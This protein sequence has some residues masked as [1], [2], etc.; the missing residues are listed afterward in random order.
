VGEQDT[1]TVVD[2]S[3]G[4]TNQVVIEQRVESL[5]FDDSSSSQSVDGAVQ[6]S[7]TIVDNRK[8]NHHRVLIMLL[9][10][11]AIFF[12]AGYYYV[13][14]L[15]TPPLPVAQMGP[16]V[17]PMI[18]VPVRPQM[19]LPVAIADHGDETPVAETETDSSVSALFVDSA[20]PLFTVAVGPFISDGDLQQ[21]TRRLEELGLQP[22]KVPGRGQVTMIRLL[23][24]V[25]PEAEARNRLKE[26][27][28]TVK[29]IFLLPLGDKLA[30]YAG[31][32]HQESRALKMQNELALQ[33]VKVSLVDSEVT[34]NGTL[35][36]AL[37][38]DQQT[39][40]EVAAHIS[41]LGLHTQLLEKK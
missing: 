39:A 4:Q 15:A 13:S 12:A 5:L 31:S 25:Y 21:A 37:Q 27:K 3:T 28:K 18:P 14:I 38:A 26:L 1:S 40:N 30:V 32:F 17:S 11:C 41:R 2:D 34:M 10:L 36:V 33:M 6:Q 16:Y 24:G 35:L 9:L 8:T 23:E 22:Q 7:V 19:N 20:V 29:S